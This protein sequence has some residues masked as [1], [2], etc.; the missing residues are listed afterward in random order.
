MAASV[1][2]AI[3][4]LAAARADAE[5]A[6]MS[7]S[8]FLAN[9]S[10]ELRTPLNA[11]IGFSD[12]LISGALNVEL[13]EKAQ[14]Y[15]S[16]IQRSGVHLLELINDILDMSAIETGELKL[17]NEPVSL[18]GVAAF[19]VGLL[20]PLAAERKI[21]V[22]N[23]VPGDFPPITGDSRRLRQ[24]AVN[25]LSNAIKYSPAGSRV[26]IHAS[27]DDGETVL[28]VADHGI[29]MSADELAI[30][31]TPFGRVENT[32]SNDEGGTGLGLPLA[33]KLVEAHGGRL[34]VDTNKGAGTTA[35]VRLPGRRI[36]N[37]ES[38]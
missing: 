18:A 14:G 32:Y 34:V 27:I 13:P 9:M 15:V 2:D 37:A 8:E 24:V 38:A 26:E 30:A 17:R 22:V 7:K 19:A 33:R 20:D 36:V 16:D 29:G 3:D 23:S 31:L 1:R 6:N 10:H 28:T 21:A 5:T 4:R 25:L 11:I 12:A 35:A